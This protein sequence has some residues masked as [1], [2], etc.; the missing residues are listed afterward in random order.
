[1]VSRF[2]S[3]QS[4]ETA[5]LLR[6]QSADGTN[7]LTRECVL[8]LTEEVR[9]LASESRALILAG[10]DR[11]FSVGADLEEI[12]ALDGPT[13]YE[14]SKMGQHL[15]EAI[16][17]FPAPVYAAVSGYCMGGGL[18]LALA[19]HYRIASPQAVFGHRGAALG[20]IT[21]WGGTQRLPRLVGRGRALE[22][23]IAA[24]RVTATRALQ[25][26]LV[27]A[28]GDDPVAEALRLISDRAERISS[29]IR[30]PT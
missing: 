22:M 11:F 6:L 23:F 9:R 29:E 4:K 27:D 12:S 25:V 13:A 26:R 18:D 3:P 10:N 21:G 7:R 30:H 16:D 19:C 17:C 5:S 1:M 24:E 2:F 14:F 28:I 8:S 20:L 15:M